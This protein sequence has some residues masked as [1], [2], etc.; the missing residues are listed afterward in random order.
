MPRRVF[1]SFH[2]D[3]IQRA[4]VVRNAQTVLAAGEEIGFY[5]SSLWES[6]K[7]QGTAAIKRLIDQGL[8]GASVIAVL[9]GSR[10]IERPWVIYEIEE[11]YRAGRGLLGIHINSIADWHNSTKP[12]EPNP[13]D[14]VGVGAGMFDR[15]LSTVVPVYDWARQ[16][17]YRNAGRWIEAAPTAAGR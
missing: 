4:N 2:Y 9:I 8:K 5:D 15:R 11:S 16:D 3:D 17:G 12:P 13:F 7:T 10:T 14:R 1:F 6:A